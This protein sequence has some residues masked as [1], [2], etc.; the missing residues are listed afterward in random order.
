MPNILER[1]VRE[2]AVDVPG[3]TRVFEELGIDYCCGG[4]RSLVDAC[5]AAGISLEQATAAL[6]AGKE[7]YSREGDG[8]WQSRSLTDLIEHIVRRH[9]EY[10][11]SELQRLDQL[12]TKVVSVH[13]QNHPELNELRE[14]F[15]E[16]RND[17]LPHMMKE[18]R[19]LFPYIEQLEAATKAGRPAPSPLFGTARNPIM[20]MIR[21]HDGAGELLRELRTA[22]R[23]Y[24]VPDDGCVS[25]RALYDALRELEQDLHQHIHLENNILFPRTVALEGAIH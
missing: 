9:H 14:R 15:L 13:G 2:L 12:S 10:T 19:V 6:E 24:V 11:K 25:Y 18:E 20:M 4:G 16:L 23:D 1:T 3:A 22:S 21:E 5:F 8:S 17:L 7:R